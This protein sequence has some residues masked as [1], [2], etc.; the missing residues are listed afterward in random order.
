MHDR[1]HVGGVAIYDGYF[2]RG[3]R[4]L[5]HVLV[6]HEVAIYGAVGSFCDYEVYLLDYAGCG[7]DD[8]AV[9]LGDFAFVASYGVSASFAL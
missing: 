9:L 1:S 2:D 3:L 5:F 7:Y 8:G 4:V 6:K